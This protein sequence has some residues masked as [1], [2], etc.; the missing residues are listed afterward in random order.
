MWVWHYEHT[1]DTMGYMTRPRGEVE[2]VLALRSEGL[3]VAEVARRTGI[4]RSTMRYWL[5]QGPSYGQRVGSACP[6]CPHIPRV[7]EGPYAYL[8]GL[9]L[10]DGCL[11]LAPRGVYR[12]R[13]T[14]DKRYP[15]IIRECRSATGL[16]L[17]NK[18]GQIDRPGCI[19]VYSNSKHWRCLF[20]QHGPGPKHRRPIVLAAWQH[21]IA[22]VRY[23]YLLLRGLIQSDGW[24][25]TNRIGGRYEYSCYQFSNRSADIRELFGAACERMGISSRQSGRWQVAVS[26]RPD[27]ARMDLIV[28]E[29]A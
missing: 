17:P 4:P 28:G 23:P 22:L 21:D 11:S 14:L 3:T 10:G 15:Q 12:L 6:P 16:V 19:E 9:Y 25:G 8:L 7:P 13:I 24:R 1:F 26:R 20:P 2:R 18:V 27:V 5:A 29:K